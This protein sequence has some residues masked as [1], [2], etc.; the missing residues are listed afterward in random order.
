MEGIINLPRSL[1]EGLASGIQD[2]NINQRFSASNDE[3]PVYDFLM[4][5]QC[6]GVWQVPFKALTWSKS[7]VPLEANT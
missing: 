7:G 5:N 3:A 6:P 4:Y 1:D 2:Q